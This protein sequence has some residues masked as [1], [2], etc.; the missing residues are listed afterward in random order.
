MSNI[1]WLVYY[2]S[3]LT[4]GDESFIE[5]ILCN[6]Y[7]IISDVAWYNDGYKDLL[8]FPQVLQIIPQTMFTVLHQIIKILTHKIREV[9]TRLEKEKMKEFAQL[10]ERYQVYYA[11]HMYT[12]T[13]IQCCQVGSP[14]NPEN[15][16]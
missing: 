9:P 16:Y 11:C 2:A 4:C 7:F 12:Y 8:Y 15:M 13:C 10:E 14:K 5:C 6:N 1:L 3:Y